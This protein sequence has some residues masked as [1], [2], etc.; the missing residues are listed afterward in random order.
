MRARGCPCRGCG[1]L[2][3]PWRPRH[4][5]RSPC[6]NAPQ[7]LFAVVVL[8]GIVHDVLQACFLNFG[9]EFVLLVDGPQGKQCV[10]KPAPFSW[11]S[12]APARNICACTSSAFSSFHRSQSGVYRR[13]DPLPVRYGSHRLSPGGADAKTAG[14]PDPV[15]RR[16]RAQQSTPRTVDAGAAWLRP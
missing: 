13:C 8:S 11:P 9:L 14:E 7:R 5:D 15:S 16:V 6:N 10:V 4:P 1:R 3:T 12:S 2:R